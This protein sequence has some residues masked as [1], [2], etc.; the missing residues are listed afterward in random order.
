[1][2]KCPSCERELDRMGVICEYCGKLDHLEKIKDTKEDSGKGSRQSK[3][4]K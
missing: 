2:K 3:D 1:M 4:N